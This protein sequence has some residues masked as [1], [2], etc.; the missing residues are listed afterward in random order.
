MCPWR[1]VDGC[2]IMQKDCSF[3]WP[4]GLL[5]IGLSK[6]PVLFADANTLTGGF[7]FLGGRYLKGND[8]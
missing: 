4:P 8:Y 5:G 7:F 1:E 2:F 3:R 6:G